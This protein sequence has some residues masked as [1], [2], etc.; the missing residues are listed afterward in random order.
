MQKTAIRSGPRKRFHDDAYRFVVEALH[1]SQ[2]RLNRPRPQSA[3]DESAHITG[4]ELLAGLREY[5]SRTFGM[6]AGTVLRSWGIRTTDDVG[7]IVFE[8]IDRGE[9]KKTDR[10]QLSDFA[11]AYDF[12]EAFIEDYVIDTQ[13]AFKRT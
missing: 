13:Q 11:H 2:Q 8:L 3:D 7:R 6:L 5:A 9:M 1:F 10:D 4:Q 12:D